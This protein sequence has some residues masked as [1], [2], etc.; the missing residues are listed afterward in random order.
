M[1]RT[2][3]ILAFAVAGLAAGT[4]QAQ[5]A[6]PAGPS[7]EVAK[8]NEQALVFARSGDYEKARELF[9]KAW[10]IQPDPTVLFNLG[11]AEL[12][13]HHTPEA[14]EHFDLYLKR[15]DAEPSKVEAIKKS[16]WSP[17]YAATGHLALPDDPSLAN[18]RLSLDGRDVQGRIFYVSPGDHELVAQSARG[19]ARARVHVVAG[20]DVDVALVPVAPQAP[21]AAAAPAPSPAVRA[22][23]A[24]ESTAPAP[25][26]DAGSGAKGGRSLLPTLLTAG[27]AVALVGLGVGAFVAAGSANDQGTSQC[28]TA[29]STNCDSQRSTVRTWDTV[30]LGAWIG[31]AALATT[32]VVLW[33][34][35][36][37]AESSKSTALVVGPGTVRLEGSF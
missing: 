37:K 9:L 32:S 27:G 17:A 12:R 6:A 18:A 22:A 26:A 28:A 16:L 7:A 10:K 8:L 1:R 5:S 15:P 33:V 4:A 3:R 20:Q 13:G 34:T 19:L 11:L 14:L 30:A 36:P 31:A 35:H 2:L 25:A 23:P 29:W 21:P 24:A